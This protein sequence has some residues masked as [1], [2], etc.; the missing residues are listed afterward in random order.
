[1]KIIKFLNV[2][3]NLSKFF[4]FNLAREK[5][6]FSPISIYNIFVHNFQ[7]FILEIIIKVE[8]IPSEFIQLSNHSL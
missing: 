3:T 4:I 7:E 1:M 8:K 2:K 6:N 5:K